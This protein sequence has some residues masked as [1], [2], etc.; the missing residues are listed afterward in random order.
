MVDN[1]TLTQADVITRLGVTQ[2]KFDRAFNITG[3]CP[4]GENLF[5]A[6]HDSV[7]I[8]LDNSVVHVC[9]KCMPKLDVEP[10]KPKPAP[11]P[12]EK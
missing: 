8:L 11:P 2:S 12:K 4:C 3:D 1:Y 6:G 9:P 5:K 7:L 10:E